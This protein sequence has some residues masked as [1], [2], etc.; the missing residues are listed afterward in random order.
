MGYVV[1][2]DLEEACRFVR[3]GL[4]AVDSVVTKSHVLEI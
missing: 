3:V 4:L 2:L 1:T